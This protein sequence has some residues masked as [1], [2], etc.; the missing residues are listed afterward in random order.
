MMVLA[1]PA[2]A[3]AQE[4][5]YNASETTLDNGMQ[6]VVIPNHRAPVVTHMVWY[7]VGGADEAQGH[8]GSAHFLE[9]LLFKGSDVIGGEPLAPGEFSKVIRRMGGNDN[10]FTGQDYTAFFQSIP[11]ENLETAMRMEA[12]RMRGAKME[13]LESE[14]LVIL[15]ERRQRT[16]N[17]P[18]GRFGEQMAAM[19]YINHPYGTPIIGWYHEMEQLDLAATKGFYDLWYG[20]NNAILIVSGDVEPDEVFTLARDIYGQV[21]RNDNV[22]ERVRTTSPVMNSKTLVTLEHPVI[23]EAVFQRLYRVPSFRQDKEVSLAMQVLEEIMGGGPTSRLYKSLVVDQKIASSAGLSY[24][25]NTYDDSGLWVYANPLPDTDIVNI[26]AAL[27]AELRAL[28][29]DGVSDEE[30]SDAKTRMQDAAIY[31]R[32]SLAGPAMVIGYSLATGS[33]LDDVET[34]P[35]QIDG[36]TAAQIQEAAKAYLNPDA[37][38]DIPPVSG[39]LL[40]KA[41]LAPIVSSEP[42]VAPEHDDAQNSEGE[43]E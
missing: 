13:E 31:A 20:P 22:P 25:A 41:D 19:A 32:D 14:R 33:T 11:S 7:K 30:L 15:E 29:A 17:D 24:S 39:V 2:F 12:G 10:A 37:P 34:W 16:D 5:V 4:K 36:V 42:D 18:R 6:V 35:A 8:S 9:H 27:D 43:T 23:R 3:A 38:R 21:P 40:P 28:I 1:F 26:E